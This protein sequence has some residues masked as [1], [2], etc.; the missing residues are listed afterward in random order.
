MDDTAKML[1]EQALRFLTS[2]YDPRL[3]PHKTG[4]LARIKWRI[5]LWWRQK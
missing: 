3:D 4:W 2:D 1:R 5:L